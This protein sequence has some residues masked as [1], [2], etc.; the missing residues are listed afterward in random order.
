ME[1]SYK[2]A[3]DECHARVF[4]RGAIFGIRGYKW[5][6]K[7]CRVLATILDEFIQKVGLENVVQIII[8]NAPVNLAAC[9]IIIEKYPHISFQGCMV[10]ALNLLLKDWG[11]Q[12]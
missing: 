9:R 3:I 1:L 12:A 7:K 4:C 6:R 8:D 11:K 2:L 5:V 10:H